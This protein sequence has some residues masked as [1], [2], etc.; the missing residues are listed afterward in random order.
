MSN[1]SYLNSKRNAFLKKAAVIPYFSAVINTALS[2]YKGHKLSK[3]QSLALAKYMHMGDRL[4]AINAIRDKV[5]LNAFNEVPQGLNDDEMADLIKEKFNKSP[6]ELGAIYRKLY[7]QLESAGEK[8]QSAARTI[9]STGNR[10]IKSIY[11]KLF[12]K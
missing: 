5:I 11:D 2:A 12:G 6:E 1:N 4:L 7:E 10:F 3:P 8:S 9:G